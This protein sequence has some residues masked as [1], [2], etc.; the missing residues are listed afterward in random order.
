VVTNE[1][2]RKILNKLP[3]GFEGKLTSTKYA[4]ITK[5]SPDTAPRDIQDLIDKKLLEK[6]A[7]VEGAP[8][9]K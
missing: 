9:I 6:K 8:V 3:D 4:R 7:E 1:R 2:Q 5:C